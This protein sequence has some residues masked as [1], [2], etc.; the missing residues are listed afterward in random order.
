MSKNVDRLLNAEM[1]RFNMGRPLS[2][3][4]SLFYE[5]VTW[6]MTNVRVSDSKE[7]HGGKAYIDDG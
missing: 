5:G 6:N 3:P 2:C 4:R 1:H 7:G